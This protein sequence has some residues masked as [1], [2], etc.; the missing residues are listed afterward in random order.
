MTDFV[1][2]YVREYH[3][4]G[5][6]KQERD[7]LAEM[8]DDLSLVVAKQ[9]DDIEA[10]NVAIRNLNRKLDEIIEAFINTAPRVNR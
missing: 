5:A 7:D 9:R 1:Y 6:T 4:H 2:L 10:R 3:A 8:V